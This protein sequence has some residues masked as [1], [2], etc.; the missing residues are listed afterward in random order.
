MEIAQ[1]QLTNYP[2]LIDFIEASDDAYRD[3]L[4]KIPL[5]NRTLEQQFNS[6][7]Q[8]A[9]VKVFYHIRGHCNDF[10]WLIGN[11]APNATG[12]KIILDNTSEEFGGNGF[13]HEQ[14]YSRFAK[15]LGVDI[16]AEIVSEDYNLQ[17]VRDFNKGHIRW[18]LK[19]D[20][21][22]KISAFAA[23]ERLD[24]IDYPALLELASNF[25]LTEHELTFFKVHIQVKHYDAMKD[26]LA[27]IW[28]VEK[29]KIIAGFNFIYQ[30]QLMMWQALSDVIMMHCS[31]IDPA[32]KLRERNDNL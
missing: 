7:Q 30:H 28:P 15:A 18:L 3:K 22:T 14:L 26:L 2:Q 29:E 21:N 24:N 12:K 4:S 31:V 8:S 5:F 17:F 20:W 1:V 32:V 23:Y 9:F 6:E 16:D 10:F 11:T 13:S 19:Q 25:N 27:E